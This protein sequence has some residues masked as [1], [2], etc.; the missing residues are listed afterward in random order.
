MKSVARMLPRRTVLL[1][2]VMVLGLL[3]TAGAANAATFT[4][5]TTNDSNDGACTASL[6]SLRDAV[7]AADTAGGS[8]TI[9]VGPG[10]YT[11]SIASTGTND[12]TTGDLDINNDSSVTITGAGS[13][14]TV[15]N[16]NGVDRAFA[17]QDGATLTLSGM[18]I[19]LGQ[20]S[21][22]SSGESDGGAVWAGGLLDV[23]ADVVFNDNAASDGGGG[24]IYLQ[25]DQGSPNTITGAT[26]TRNSGNGGGAIYDDSSD[27]LSITNT[28]FANNTS[29][30]EGGA[31]YGDADGGMTISGGS[32]TDNDAVYGGGFYW[33]GSSAVMVT[34]TS[35][36]GNA[37]A[38]EEGGAVF[39]EA[40][41]GMTLQSDTF[42]GDYA[43]YGGAL[44]L[45]SSSGN[46]AL[47]GDEF[48]DNS[49]TFEGGAVFWV[50][51][52]LSSTGSSFVGNIAND[53]GGLFACPTNASDML[54]LTDATISLN[55][56]AYGGGVDLAGNGCEDPQVA[57]INDTIAFNTA[58]IGQGGGVYGT[59]AASAPSPGAPGLENTIIAE[60]TGGDCG[61]NSG[62]TQFAASVDAVGSNLDSDSSCFGGL[63]GPGDKTGV[64]PL[65]A[66]PANNGGSVLTDAELPGSPAIDAGNNANCASTTDA[67]GIGRPQGNSCDMG[68]YEAAPAVLTMSK[69]APANGTTNV[70]I[71]YT[72]T[73][74]NGGPGPSSATTLVDQLPAGET[75]FGT[76]PSQGSCTSAGTPAKVTCNLGVMNPA[77]TA[78]VTII[79]A[80]ANVGS[81]TN[82]ATVSNDQGSSATGSATTMFAAASS[83][84]T[85]PP[86]AITGRAKKI[87]HKS[88]EL[89][90]TVKTG[91]F[92]TEY[93]FEVGRTKSYG[94]VTKLK[95][96]TR[97]TLNVSATLKKL[98]PGTKYHYRL[99]AVNSDGTGHGR[100]R[101]FKTS[102]HIG[103]LVL[104]S[105]HLTGTNGLVA[106]PLTC[107]SSLAC[108][109]LFSITTDSGVN[110]QTATVV[111]TVSHSTNYK[112]GAG[113]TETIHAQLTAACLS[114]LEA[115][116]GHTITA[117]F[118]SRARSGQF[119]VIKIIT[120]SLG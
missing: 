29:S 96:T 15:I 66:Q 36:T 102:G 89:T 38:W 105:L 69:T 101:T 77:G 100:D 11:Y 25:S 42:T 109:G 68:A 52:M 53:G 61:D 26:F 56:A 86:T 118:S 103:K 113:K 24:A 46:Y 58:G 110:G 48:D 16:P 57:M 34:G 78:T 119:G 114:L 88:A 32:F 117:K 82:T 74:N 55:N 27:P 84:A 41:T 63:G 106:A 65:L 64:N 104:D 33:N 28:S 85:T 80:E 3:G 95:H 39:D 62:T 40:S 4:V 71:S 98:R 8:N 44:Y 111:C 87:H 1:S 30:D 22:N 23:T 17:V 67:R 73:I 37:G 12:P 99:V 54:S 97:A 91:G 94:T 72:L 107:D 13:G 51:G 112:I 31:I 47:N 9:L 43:G 49:A 35:F 2:V 75:L 90:G 45:S 92:G 59:S 81:V 79:A 83:S 116:P 20:P 76:N 5:T 108:H 70:P 18:T 7:V 50:A 10:T 60:N 14:S 19:E 93:F 120:L 115:A 6:C 21:N